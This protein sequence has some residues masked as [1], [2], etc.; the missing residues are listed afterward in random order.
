MKLIKKLAIQRLQQIIL[1]NPNLVRND[2]NHSMSDCIRDLVKREPTKGM[3]LPSQLLTKDDI[4]RIAREFTSP[5]KDHTKGDHPQCDP[6][7]LDQ[8][9]FKR[10][11]SLYF[12]TD[13]EKAQMLA[14]TVQRT[15]A[16]FNIRA[17]AVITSV[18]VLGQRIR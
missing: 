5:K 1:E 9:D 2:S 15:C 7:I 16:Y 13:E 17:R 12:R 11:Q 14:S 6:A 10:K 8:L 3:S 4:E 18:N